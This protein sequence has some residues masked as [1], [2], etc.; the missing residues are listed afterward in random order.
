M[1][2]WENEYEYP[3]KRDDR[4]TI[5]SLWE[6]MNRRRDPYPSSFYQ[7]NEERQHTPDPQKR[8]PKKENNV[9]PPLIL[10]PPP[11]TAKKVE[12]KTEVKEEFVPK[13][14][15][16]EIIPVPDESID[17]Y[18]VEKEYSDEDTWEHAEPDWE[19]P[20]EDSYEDEEMDEI[21]KSDEEEH[22]HEEEIEVM[23]VED[24]PDT[25]DEDHCCKESTFIPER[26]TILAKLPVMI[27]KEKLDIDVFNS[28]NIM[29]PV[30]EV[31][32][33]SWRIRS[34]KGHAVLPSKTVFVKLVL[35]ADMD[36][37]SEDGTLR[38]LQI[39]VPLE[40]NLETKWIADPELSFN[41]NHEY[42]F[43]SKFDHHISVH[44]SFEETLVSPV[45]F[46]YN[47]FNVI[48]HQ[49]LIEKPD[50]D[51]LL[52]LKGSASLTIEGYQDQVV[53]VEI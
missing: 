13:R 28:F 41:N 5:T 34:F 19:L 20:E 42:W 22:D 32:D 51:L 9:A 17:E 47:S 25:K 53:E 36:F 40:R 14:K 16:E 6:E 29:L 48:W 33:M 8:V 46:K 27:F 31:T 52:G 45:T 37:V 50:G 15:K 2:K 10:S 35:V 23:E 21:Y 4:R 18:L 39:E 7:D 24:E 38:S 44:R 43:R 3:R 11:V 30:C 26:D 1:S 12:R 49:E